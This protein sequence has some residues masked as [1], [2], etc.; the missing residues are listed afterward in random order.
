[1]KKIAA[2]LAALTLGA[3]VTTETAEFKPTVGQEAIVRDGNPALVSKKPNSIVLARPASR[4][5][6]IGARPVYVIAV[7]NAGPQSVLL[8]TGNIKVQQMRDGEPIADLKVFTYDDLVK[9]EQARQVMAAI[10]V[11]VAAGA[12]AAAAANAGNY[13]STSTIYTPRGSTTVYTTGYNPTAAAIAQSNAAANSAV[14][15]SAAVERGQ[16]NMAALEQ[17][18]LKD[19]TV[20]PGE[21]VGG[22]VHFAPPANDASGKSYRISVTVGT[23]VH[24]IDVAQQAAG[25]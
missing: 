4:K 19:N 6:Q 23:D 7:M 20:M 24:E 10:L 12:S 11:G 18:V 15:M 2:A 17:Q 9:E 21:W 1:M 5:F 8:S 16:Q 25:S 14:M 13:R 3:C 22:Q